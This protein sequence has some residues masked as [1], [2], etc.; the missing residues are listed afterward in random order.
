MFYFL[1]WILLC[2]AVGSIASK[3]GRTGL[4]W[5]L[6]SLFISPLLGFI[7]LSVLKNIQKEEE[8]EI[9]IRNRIRQQNE[10]DEKHQELIDTLKTK[11][12][13]EIDDN[14]KCHF[15]AEIIKKEAV[16]CRFCHKDLN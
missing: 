1:F 2:I 15:C 14:K 8:K 12:K 6:I 13:N 10:I 4:G 9:E 5:F 11:E 16:F 3:R 7:I